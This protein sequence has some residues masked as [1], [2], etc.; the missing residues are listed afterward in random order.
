MII[1]INFAFI[2]RSVTNCSVSDRSLILK[3]SAHPDPQTSPMAAL[4]TVSKDFFETRPSNKSPEECAIT[5]EAELGELTH[6][7]FKGVNP[8][9]PTTSLSQQS[10]YFPP[11]LAKKPHLSSPSA[12]KYGP[13]PCAWICGVNRDTFMIRRAQFTW[14][15]TNLSPR[16][17]KQTFQLHARVFRRL[18]NGFV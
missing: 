4:E 1:Q 17:K 6:T 8:A 5:A 9:L 14:M 16:N 18:A 10:H 13:Q 3:L 12:L 15:F 11:C 7:F 2:M